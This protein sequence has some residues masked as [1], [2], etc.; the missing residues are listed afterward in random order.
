MALE[1]RILTP[2]GNKSLPGK[3]PLPPVSWESPPVQDPRFFFLSLSLSSLPPP[4]VLLFLNLYQPS[5]FLE[6]IF[7]RSD[8]TLIFPPVRSSATVFA[9]KFIGG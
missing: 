8:E 1:S 6:C 2:R 5:E 3:F 4:L 7:P 9:D